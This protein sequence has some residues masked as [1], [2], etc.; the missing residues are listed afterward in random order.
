MNKAIRDTPSWPE[1]SE[2]TPKTLCSP[3]RMVYLLI[4]ELIHLIDDDN[5]FITT[6][7]HLFILFYLIYIST[8]VLLTAY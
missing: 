5:Y 3:S 1:L 6:P 4:V 2:P 8:E 7:V